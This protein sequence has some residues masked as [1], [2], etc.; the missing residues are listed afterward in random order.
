MIHKSRLGYYIVYRVKRKHP[1]VNNK[2]KKNTLK[3][4]TITIKVPVC[5][6]CGSNMSQ[7]LGYYRCTKCNHKQKQN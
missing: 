4:R 5:P 6:K 3:W 1:I 2:K 7:A